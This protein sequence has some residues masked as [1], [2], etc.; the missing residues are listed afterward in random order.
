[1]GPFEYKGY[2]LENPATYFGASGNNHHWIFNFKNKWYI[3]Y[4]TQTL[5]KTVGLEKGGYR[6][7]FIDNFN[8]NED[9]SLPIQKGTKEGVAQVVSFNPYDEIPAATFATS[10]NV[11]VTD[12]Q[13]LCPV[14][15][16]AYICIKGVDLSKG[17]KKIE[18][19]FA[20]AVKRG[21]RSSDSIKVMINN[22]GAN[23]T[24]IGKAKL[25]KKVV[26][27]C[28]LKLSE[29]DSKVCDLYFVFSGNCELKSWKMK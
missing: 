26:L 22:F 4:H 1:L 28:D 21:F 16:G 20:K 15:N 23:G 10:R 2:T 11:V 27:N 12:S 8:V 14:K 17:A 24:V 3:A 7:L 9:G 25:N 19:T 29:S 18:F 13:T 5:E 6:A